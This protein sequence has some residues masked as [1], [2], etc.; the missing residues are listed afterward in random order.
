MYNKDK[1]SSSPITI[2]KSP[3]PSPILKFSP[4][5]GIWQ[6]P[7]T[8]KEFTRDR[9]YSLPEHFLSILNPEIPDAVLADYEK[10]K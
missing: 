7:S 9:G 5:G 3:N 2:V 10:M 8:P 1:I 6:E 4:H